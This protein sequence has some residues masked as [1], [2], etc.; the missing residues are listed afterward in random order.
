MF[1]IQVVDKLKQFVDSNSFSINFIIFS[2][3]N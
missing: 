3:I 1:K 2:L